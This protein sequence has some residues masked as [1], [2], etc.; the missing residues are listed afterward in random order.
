MYTPTHLYTC[1]PHAYGTQTNKIGLFCLHSRN[2][3]KHKEQQVFLW[4]KLTGTI[5]FQPLAHGS[6]GFQQGSGDFW[7]WT[8]AKGTMMGFCSEM[9]SLPQKPA[10]TKEKR[11]TSLPVSF[12]V[13]H[14]EHHDL[15]L[16][17]ASWRL[18]HLPWTMSWTWAYRDHC[19]NGRML[20]FCV[21]DSLFRQRC[22][23][24][25]DLGFCGRTD[26]NTSHNLS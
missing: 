17:L 7:F 12:E 10:N 14:Q 4:S 5:K 3:S 19:T 20:W 2:A 25:L 24:W 13:T 6:G 16:G 15:S 21:E 11:D 18:Y 1:S 26:S 8:F 23:G 22:K 9:S